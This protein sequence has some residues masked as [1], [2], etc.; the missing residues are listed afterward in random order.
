M[1]ITNFS[2]LKTAIANWLDRS[3]LT[4][5]IPDFITLAEA[6]MYRGTGEDKGLRLRYMEQ[7]ATRDMASG[8]ERYGLPSDFLEMRNISYVRDSQTID[9]VLRAPRQLDEHFREDYT[10]YPEAFAIEGTEIRI[11]PIP[12]G[13]WTMRQVYY[14]KLDALSD[15]STENDILTNFPDIYLFG[16]LAEAELYLKND[17]RAGLWEQRFLAA[18]RAANKDHARTRWKG[19]ALQA[20]SKVGKYRTRGI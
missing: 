14:K 12:S 10:G 3:D 4:T 6:R 1:A 5:I 13:T 19:G 20:V 7:A 2:E 9:L 18:I 8:T 17:Q 15:S 16:S 11:R